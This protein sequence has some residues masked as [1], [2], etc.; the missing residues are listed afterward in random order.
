[1]LRRIALALLAPLVVAACSTS[2]VDATQQLKDAAAA[3]KNVKTAQLDS[4]SGR[5]PPSRSRALA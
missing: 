5:A 1:M 3:L 2:T 4:S